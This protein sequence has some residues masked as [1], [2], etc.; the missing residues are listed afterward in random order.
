MIRK[1][2]LWLNRLLWT[3]LVISLL[4]IASYVSLGRYYVD[5]IN[6]Y[7]Q[8]LTRHFVDMTGMPLEVNAVAADWSELSPILTLDSI[9]FFS[10]NHL[11]STQLP[12]SQHH[13]S[14]LS[15]QRATIEVNPIKSLLYRAPQVRWLELQ[16]L[17]F[18]LEEF[19][20][21]RWR[22][23]GYELE[24]SS[25][26][27][28]IDSVIDL[29]LAADRL[30]VEASVVQ[31][32]FLDG[33]SARIDLKELSLNRGGDFRRVR[34]TLGLEQTDKHIEVLLES[35]GDPRDKETF[36][37][38][39]YA[40]ID[41]ID[42]K[43]QLPLLHSLGLG[44]SEAQLDTELWLNIFS[45]GRWQLEGHI[46]TPEVDLSTMA[47]EAIDSIEDLR[48]TFIAEKSQN[49]DWQL[50]LPEFFARWREESFQLKNLQFSKTD[51]H[52]QIA[53]Q[54]IKLEQFVDQ[55]VNIHVLGEKGESTLE[56][57][58]P[59]GELSNVHL[60]LSHTDK[61]SFLLQAEMQNVAVQS[62]NGAPGLHG[63]NGYV[64]VNNK[65]GL[66]LLDTDHFVMDFPQVYEKAMSFTAAQA[67][68]G[69][70]IEDEAV[71]VSSGPIYLRADH[72]PASGLLR[73]HLPLKP[74]PFPSMTL[75]VG[76][77]NT[78]ATRRDKFIPKILN[79]G[80]LDWLE[81]SIPSGFIHSAGFIYRGSL[82]KNGD[83]DRTVQLFVDTDNTR[84]DYHPDWPV[85]E[86]VQGLVV[87]D[88]NELWVSADEG[89]ISNLQ[90]QFADVYLNSLTGKTD[91]LTIN[92]KSVGDAAG[93]LE[94]L[95]SAGL[96]K[97]VGD[98]FD[99]WQMK[100]NLT[101]EV[102]LKIPLDNPKAQPKINVKTS[103][104]KTTLGLP[105][106][107]LTFDQLMGE[108]RYSDD[109]GLLSKNLKG[110]FFNKPLQA[111][112]AQQDKQIVVDVDALVDMKSVQKWTGQPAVNFFR[113]EANLKAKLIVGADKDSLLNIQSNLDGV[114]IDLPEP[115]NKKAAEKW[116]YNLA[117]P[118]VSERPVLSMSIDN[119]VG[120][121]LAFSGQDFDG[122]KITLGEQAAPDVPIESG[123]IALTGALEQFDLKVWQPIYDRYNEYAG[124]QKG[125][126]KSD[127]HFLVK[128]LSIEH[129]M[130]FD[131]SFERGQ[132]G[133]HH[134][135]NAWQVHWN[136]PV[137]DVEMSLPD[138]TDQSLALTFARLKI[139]EAKADGESLLAGVNPADLADVDIK[140]QQLFLGEE[141]WGDL[142]FSMNT[143]PSGVLL[144]NIEGTLR[145]VQLGTVDS[146]LIFAWL[147]DGD[148][149]QSFFNGG[150]LFKDFGDVLERWGYQRIIESKNGLFDLSLVWAGRPDQWSL[151]SSEGEVITDIDEGRF[152]SES[153]GTVGALKVVGILN[154][155]NLMR[156]LRLDF[157]DITKKGVKFDAIDGRVRLGQGV[158]TIQDNLVI[159]SPSSGFQLRGTADL[160]QESLDME[161]VATLPVAS[162]LPWIAALAG[163]L[164]TAAG[165]YVASKIF[166]K[167]VD[168]L[169]SAVYSVKGDWNEPEMKFERLFSDKGKLSKKTTSQD[170]ERTITDSK[171]S[172]QDLT[173]ESKQQ[174]RQ[175][176]TPSKQVGGDVS[177]PVNEEGRR[178]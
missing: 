144:E 151:A 106:Y 48:F 131:M 108:V 40:K 18:A 107:R 171:T 89:L 64:E 4:L 94:I 1:T 5:H 11:S 85:L 160:Q 62:W 140:I 141:M 77:K 3:G 103:L 72:G 19:E 20:K 155:T 169:S 163:G 63:V 60:T 14:M 44:I 128:Q 157:S 43:R 134:G 143:E 175:E 154:F 6:N 159:K 97:A 139:P 39:S 162:N 29:L 8:M 74:E 57:L 99:N 165:V 101:A 150:L 2:A 9:A 22:L 71:S 178:E 67:A 133:V 100:G 49:N 12:F 125:G 158:L 121:Q 56:Q 37:M 92:A 47:G 166:G 93:G 51:K 142:S 13:E 65:N 109:K 26:M 132:L 98:T 68:V 110:S 172:P 30:S 164:P 90:I 126:S 168:K 58:N 46:A 79:P 91:W 78:E 82:R 23:K 147:K 136:N 33:G 88:D 127:P 115:F 118:L 35:E 32:Y 50:W 113:G 104:K 69:W 28:A 111:S 95:R 27:S 173:Q 117:M 80:L 25:D 112:I 105:D 17:E 83:D 38:S 55:L 167:S 129:L 123:E 24:T 7:Q 170:A 84:L 15:I 137:M 10:P 149:H 76:L 153:G 54:N 176:P 102:S 148:R 124:K 59:E 34:L 156:R 66:V 116:H 120:L 87:V 177:L 86:Q 138:N 42:F 75:L 135:D 119:R 96:K 145:G 53:L 81:R 36:A 45:G 70:A 61:L 161:L 152:L 31:L 146:P 21:G 41:D 114:T 122:G 130:A 73:L 174:P 52:Y 16:G